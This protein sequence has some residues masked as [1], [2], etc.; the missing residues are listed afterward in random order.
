MDLSYHLVSYPYSNTAFILSAAF[1]LELSN[2]LHWYMLQT[3][4]TTIC[5]CC[6]QLLFKSAERRKDNKYIIIL[7]Y[8]PKWLTL[9]AL[10]IPSF[11]SSCYLFLFILAW[12]IPFS[13]SRRADSLVIDSISICS[14]ENVIITPSCLE[15]NVAVY[16]NLTV[17]SAVWMCHPTAFWPPL[18]L[19]KFKLLILLVFPCLWWAV[20][21]FLLFSFAFLFEHFDCNVSRCGSLC[22]YSSWSF[23]H[24]LDV[25]M[26]I[27]TKF[28]KFSVT[29]SSNFLSASFS[30]FSLFWYYHYAYVFHIS[31]RSYFSSF[32]FFTILLIV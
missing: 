29:I 11:G 25:Y 32:C 17:F 26:N 10:I 19:M 23:M 30:F 1:V 15:D 31:L 14:P 2:R 8:F 20:F 16:R 9:L 22:A 28:G 7:L 13:I 3:Q 24:C 6:I 4:N 12:N 5:Y 27:F 18:F 21:L